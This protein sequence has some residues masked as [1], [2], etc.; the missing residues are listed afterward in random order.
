[1]KKRC[2]FLA[3]VV[4]VAC[5]LP[6]TSLRGEVPPLINYQGKL[7]D[8]MGID[9]NREVEMAFA[10]YTEA[11]GGSA[12]WS[13]TRGVT[14]TDGVFN[15]LLGSV[16]PLEADCFTTNP[17]TYLG[18]TVGNDTE[19]TP[20]QRIAAVPYALKTA[21]INLKDGKIGIGT[22]D[23]TANLEVTGDIKTGGNAI[24]PL[25]PAFRVFR[26]GGSV[27]FPAGDHI[28]NS[29]EFNIG[30]HYNLDTGRFTA[31]VAGIYYFKTHF[32]LYTSYTNT[33][34]NYIGISKN[35]DPMRTTNIGNESYDG[36]LEI[37]ALLQ[38]S[39][40]DYVNTRANYAIGT[41]SGQY[42]SFE[43]FMVSGI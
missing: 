8:V 33:T 37:S 17:E 26:S 40:G 30:N 29:V 18:I 41:F 15:V 25:I 12:V 9:V 27:T 38:L 1:M 14:V 28:F 39:A 13:E 42:N 31:P 32:F 22:S 34:N 24:S 11:S 43:G 10:L 21:G 2:E 19:M 3:I 4:L 6:W 7:T 16:I 20:R 36:G 35:G 5:L 23:P